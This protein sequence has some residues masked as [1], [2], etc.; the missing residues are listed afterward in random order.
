M[1]KRMLAIFFILSVFHIGL[2]IPKTK[3]EC[4]CHDFPTKVFSTCCNC[5]YC[6][7]QRGG[8]LSACGCHE[9]AGS[10]SENL[11]AI[12]RALCFCGSSEADF[13]LPGLKYPALAA[14]NLNSLPT[15]E[16]HHFLS[17]STALSSQ[18][19]LTPP[20]HPS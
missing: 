18:I 11:P 14:K 2:I 19:Y 4:S 20:E 8:F 10:S 13:E 3:F 7:S 5:S 17:I 15:L 1:K 16:I 6:V 12:K 9:R